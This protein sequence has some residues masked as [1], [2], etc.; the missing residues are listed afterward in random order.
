[1]TFCCYWA[2]KGWCRTG[3]DCPWGH[4]DNKEVAEKKA[5]GCEIKC[6]DDWFDGACATTR[7]SVSTPEI[8][9]EG[10][11]EKPVGSLA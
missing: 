5:E 8:A 10:R 2:R 4:L 11:G 9:Q 1:M 7:G 6:Q 3:D